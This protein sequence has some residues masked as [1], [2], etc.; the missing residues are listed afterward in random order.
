MKPIAVGDLVV[1]TYP[2]PCG[3]TGGIGRIFRVDE[4]AFHL[5][6]CR[7]CGNIREVLAARNPIRKTWVDLPRLK[8]L[9]PDALKDDIPEREEL[10]A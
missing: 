6:A 1:V 8:R 4:I 2:A 10:T 9:D 5:G 7:K 3:C